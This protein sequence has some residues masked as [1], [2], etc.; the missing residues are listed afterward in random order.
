MSAC[1]RMCT[2]EGMFAHVCACMWKSKINI[3]CLPLS[4]T[5]VC[6]MLYVQN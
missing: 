2:W 3:R 6:C 1:L 5:T 4:P